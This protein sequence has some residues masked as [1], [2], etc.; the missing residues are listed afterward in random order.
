[1][2]ARPRRRPARTAIAAATVLF[3]APTGRIAVACAGAAVLL[4]LA[5][6]AALALGA[7]YAPHSAHRTAARRTLHLLLRLAPWY[8]DPPRRAS[9]RR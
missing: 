4:L 1:M 5:L 9:S 3:L 6:T 8:P 2:S 7:A